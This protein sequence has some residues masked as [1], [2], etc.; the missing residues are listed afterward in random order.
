MSDEIQNTS[1]HRPLQIQLIDNS[2]HQLPNNIKANKNQ[3][4]SN[5]K[6]MKANIAEYPKKLEH[7]INK[8]NLCDLVNIANNSELATEYGDAN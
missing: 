3:I 7:E 6:W 1:D 4:A 8:S 5:I 2:V